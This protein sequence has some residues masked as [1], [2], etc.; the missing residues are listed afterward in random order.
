MIQNPLT[1]WNLSKNRLP[2]FLSVYFVCKYQ[3][4]ANSQGYGGICF[5]KVPSVSNVN[6]QV[7]VSR[8]ILHVLLTVHGK[9]IKPYIANRATQSK[10]KGVAV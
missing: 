9:S 1:Q 10:D 3:P 2:S 6:F 8:S 4:Q 5:N 7:L